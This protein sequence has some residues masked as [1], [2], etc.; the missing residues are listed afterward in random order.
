[1]PWAAAEKFL[2]RDKG[3]ILLSFSGCWRYNAVDA[4]K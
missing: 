2:G 1:M 3:D 4:Y